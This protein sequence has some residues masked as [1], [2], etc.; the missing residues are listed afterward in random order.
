MISGC[1][2]LGRMTFLFGNAAPLL[3]EE[4]I[5]RTNARRLFGCACTRV[6]IQQLYSFGVA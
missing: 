2:E 5:F 3:S 6:F 4:A 1:G